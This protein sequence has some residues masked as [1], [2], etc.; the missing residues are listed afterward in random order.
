[1]VTFSEDAFAVVFSGGCAL[2]LTC[3]LCNLVVTDRV[4]VKLCD[5]P[6]LPHFFPTSDYSNKMELFST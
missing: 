4:V 1:M 5:S 6:F 3:K 2:E